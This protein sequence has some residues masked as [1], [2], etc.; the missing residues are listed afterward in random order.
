MGLC[1]SIQR[2]PPSRWSSDLPPELL[3][4]ILCRLLS[5]ADRLSFRAVC[6]HWRLAEQQQ[7]PLSS[8][9]PLVRIRP[10]ELTFRSLASGELRRFTAS[11]L[12]H[13]RSRRAIWCFLSADGWLKYEVANRARTC[14]LV[15]PLSGATIDVPAAGLG[16]LGGGTVWSRM[17]QMTVCSPDLIAAVFTGGRVGF[18]RPG[19]R[20]WTIAC[21]LSAMWYDA[22]AFYH[23]K[24]Y[25]LYTNDLFAYEVVDGDGDPSGVAKKAHAAKHVIKDVPSVTNPL[26]KEHNPSRISYLV[27]AND[28]L[29][30]V[31]WRAPPYKSDPNFEEDIKLKVFEADLGQSQPSTSASFHSIKYGAT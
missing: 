6:R 20:S 22:L 1:V 23:G 11:R 25:A 3:V 28:K 18:Y 12:P 31:T 26:N 5:D 24:L 8:A 4:L 13:A 2:R 21:D 27:V 19:G 15:N 30:M 17:I 14:F 9:L 7:R 29:L 10:H 16:D